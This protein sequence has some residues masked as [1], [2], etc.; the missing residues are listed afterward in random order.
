MKKTVILLIIG[1]VSLIRAHQAFAIPA[2][3][4]YI[5]GADYVNET[6]V[7]SDT[8]FELWVIAARNVNDV[9]LTM[10]VEGAGQI[11]INGHDVTD[12]GPFEYGN[13]GYHAHDV[14]PAWY[15]EYN[16][17]NMSITAGDDIYNMPD[18]SEGQKGDQREFH[19][20]I[21]G[22]DSVHF[23]ARGDGIR[24]NGLADTFAPP[25]HDAQYQPVPEPMT[26]SLLGIGLVGLL[27]R[28]FRKVN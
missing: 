25:S 1:E 23:D 22:F 13:P 20:T 17:G 3:Q 2:L 7:T 28:K 27:G 11:M 9:W 19:I 8:S 15:A 12:F 26:M 10:A 14:Y 4:V 18:M 16:I 21:S 5:P 6:W 24:K